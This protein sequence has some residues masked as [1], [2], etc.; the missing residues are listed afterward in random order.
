MFVCTPIPVDETEELV[1]L[2]LAAEE[3]EARVLAVLHDPAYTAYA[4]RENG[5]LV[6]AA[7]MHWMQDG[8]GEIVYIAV[9]AEWQGQ[10]YGKRMIAN[11][12]GELRARG[13][14]VLLVGTAN[15]SLANLAFYQKCGFRLLEIK[16]DYFDYIQPPVLENGIPIRDMVVLRYEVEQDNGREN[17]HLIT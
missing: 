5:K 8:P 11:L 3:G 2:L 14:S 4:A 12:Q 13:G 1:P 10:G 17:L 9:H 7:V 6:G 16:R 15:S